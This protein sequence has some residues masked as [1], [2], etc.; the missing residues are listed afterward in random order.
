[1]SLSLLPFLAVSILLMNLYYF[2]DSAR[3]ICMQS[4]LMQHS[5]FELPSNVLF[6]CRDILPVRC[7]AVARVIAINFVLPQYT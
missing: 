1:M 4:V 5:G 3:E 6:G 2:C 7:G